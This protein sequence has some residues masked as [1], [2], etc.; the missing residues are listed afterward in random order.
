MLCFTAPRCWRVMRGFERFAFIGML[1]VA[2][3][4]QPPSTRQTFE[5]ADVRVSAPVRNP[6]MQGGL[7][8]ELRYEL[9]QA[10]MLDMIRT[11]YGV[12]ADAIYWEGRVGWAGTVSM[13]SCQGASLG[14]S[15]AAVKVMLQL[16]LADRCRTRRI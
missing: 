7:L 10:S 1:S 16:L 3:F 5:M 13:W 9:R 12:D 8:P 11:A 6:K 2:A 15:A 14:V 4:G